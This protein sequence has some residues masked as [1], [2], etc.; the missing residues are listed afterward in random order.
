MTTVLLRDLL[1][2]AFLAPLSAASG[3]G[4]ALQEELPMQHH[5]PERQTS[6]QRWNILVAVAFWASCKRALSRKGQGLPA[7]LVASDRAAP[8]WAQG[9]GPAHASSSWLYMCMYGSMYM[10]CMYA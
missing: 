4:C 1:P 9:P 8:G 2:I 7:G 6:I 3:S 10:G 5:L